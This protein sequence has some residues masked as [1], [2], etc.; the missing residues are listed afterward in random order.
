MQVVDHNMQATEEWRAG[1]VTRMRVSAVTGA[2]ALCIFEQWCAPGTGAPN[3]THSV[4]EVLTILDG[5]AE[6]WLGDDQVL[7]SVGQSVIVPAGIR[8]GFRN[9]AA[10]TLHIQGTLASSTFEAFVDGQEEPTRRWLA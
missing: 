6:I 2:V 9:A 1:V 7:A 5:Q 4:E 8:H 10:A 3:H